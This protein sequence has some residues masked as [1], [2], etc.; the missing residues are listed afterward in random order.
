MWVFCR[1]PEATACA[2]GGRDMTV[3]V[4]RLQT[5]QASQVTSLNVVVVISR[6]HLLTQP[7]KSDEMKARVLK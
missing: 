7:N 6:R 3:R 2:T 4:C 1:T 5:R